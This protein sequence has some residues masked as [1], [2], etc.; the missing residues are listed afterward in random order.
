M[1]MNRGDFETLSAAIA[2]SE[3]PAEFRRALAFD[4]ADALTGTNQRF[5]PVLWLRECEVGDI[6]SQDVAAW[7]KRLNSRV[8]SIRRKRRAY[9]EREGTPLEKY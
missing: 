1:A 7:T 4:I 9:E 6:E 8:A 2:E 3:V 5:D